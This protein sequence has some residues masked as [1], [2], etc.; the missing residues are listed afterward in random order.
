MWLKISYSPHKLQD[1][2]FEAETVRVEVLGDTCAPVAESDK[3]FRLSPIFPLLE[4]ALQPELDSLEIHFFEFS[5]PFQILGLINQFGS[6]KLKNR[7]Y[8]SCGACSI[9]FLA[10]EDTIMEDFNDL[11]LPKAK[12]SESWIVKNGYIAK[13]TYKQVESHFGSL[14]TVR[15]YAQLPPALRTIID[16]FV[17]SIR[18]IASKSDQDDNERIRLF[19]RLVK[20]VDGFIE[21]LI[22]LHAPNG[23]APETF[24]KE[25]PEIH[26]DSLVR[27]RYIHQIVDRLIQIN[28]ALSY[29]STQMHSGSVPLLER[30]SLIRR[31]SLL[32]IGAALRTLD[33]VVGFIETA[34]RKINFEEIIQNRLDRAKPLTLTTDPTYP[35]RSD[36]GLANLETFNS[37]AP[38]DSS[39]QKLVYFSSRNGFRESEFAI[40]AA[41]NALWNGLSLE[42]SLMTITHEMLHSHVRLLLTFL[43]FCANGSETDNYQRF[44]GRFYARM[45]EGRTDV[46]YSLLDSIR[47]LIFTYCLITKT[48]GSITE[49]KGFT[50]ERKLDAPPAY[51]AF[52]DLFRSE[53][54]NINEILVHVLDLHYFYGGR[55]TK[56]IPLIWSSWSAVPNVR[57]DLRQYVLRSLLAIASKSNTREFKRFHSAVEDFKAILSKN[58]IVVKRFPILREVQAILSDKE[59]LRKDYYSSFANS[60]ILVDLAKEILFSETVA[61]EVT[62]DAKVS[63]HEREDEA[64]TDFEYSLPHGFHN[65]AVQSPIAFLFDRMLKVLRGEFQDES[66]ER[67]V[68]TVLLA[69]NAR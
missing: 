53:F 24:W 45:V 1:Y 56:Y 11:K 32:G 10:D 29:V 25:N 58:E 31:N 28:S 68:T 47:E 49:S 4:H 14:K 34:F 41:L 42:W 12:A 39:T 17:V 43:F 21:E 37:T 18:L 23:P 20:R 15:D 5:N 66:E 61:A 51:P 7:T 36:W 16:E 46:E 30:R 67:D 57:A 9:L 38:V 27:D 3:S 48:A 65:D 44:Y 26:T 8:F 69:M 59:L 64:E 52:Y 50:S 55:A 2:N 54:R 35:D 62:K 13:A 6:P 63:P 33:R 40:T 19:E 60:L 22:Y